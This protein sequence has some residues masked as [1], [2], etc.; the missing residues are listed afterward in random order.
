ML[1]TSR[2]LRFCAGCV[3]TTC[4]VL[5][6]AIADDF[7]GDE[8]ERTVL[9][10]VKSREAQQLAKTLGTMLSHKNVQIA[11]DAESN[12]LVL[13]GTK[14]AIDETVQLLKALD[15]PSRMVNIAV[16][17]SVVDPEADGAQRIA[18][19]LELS[20]L[21][22][23]EASLQFGQQ[24]AVA[25]GSQQYGPGRSQTVR[26]TEQTGTLVRATPQIMSDGVRLELMVE[27]SWLEYPAADAKGDGASDG[28]VPPTTYT[29][30]AQTT[31]H[32]TTGKSQSIKAM[33]SG[34]SSVREAVIR[35]SVG[36]GDQ[37]ATSVPTRGGRSSAENGS[38]TSPSRSRSG[39]SRGG[40][41]GGGSQSD[42]SRSRSGGSGFGPKGRPEHLAETIFER[43]DTN[44]DGRISGDERNASERLL[45]SLGFEPSDKVT[46][47]QFIDEFRQRMQGGR[48]TPPPL[49]SGLGGK[50]DR[51][52]GDGATDKKNSSS[53]EPAASGQE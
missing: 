32:L 14:T 28:I 27:K 15:Q 35:V 18:D 49:R 2:S 25:T 24:V 7:A 29:T 37:K 4:F 12:V 11:A 19:Q 36:I 52:F 45:R 8:Q 47:D 20:T 10:A 42:R 33:V 48:G 9:V 46:R 53:E 3:L 17:I 39:A 43:F 34:G 23:H 31:L 22:E 50:D 6:S 1:N 5:S 26:R 38:S 21:D 16:S 30:V 13:K 51:D 40:F 41:G 44:K